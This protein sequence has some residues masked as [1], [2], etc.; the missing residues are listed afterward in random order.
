MGIVYEVEHVHTTE[1]LALKLGLA[2]D[3]DM[4]ERFRREARTWARLSHDHVVRIIDA[5][6]STTRNAPYLVMELLDGFNLEALVIHRGPIPPARVVDLLWQIARAVDQAHS[7]GIVHRDLKPENVFIHRVPDGRAMVK[8][9]DWGIAKNLDD[10]TTDIT[11]TGAILGTPLYMAP[12]QAVGKVDAIGRASDI[13]AVGLIA[14]YLLTGDDYWQADDTGVLLQRVGRGATSKP[15]LRWSWLP[16]G[17]DEWFAR[18]CMREP[19]KRWS[20]VGEQAEALREAFDLSRDTLPQALVAERLGAWLSGGAPR[21]QP[22]VGP[23]AKADREDAHRP[24]ST[25]RPARRFAPREP[26]LEP[27]PMARR[28]SLLAPG[29]IL[30]AAMFVVAIARLVPSR[31][32]PVALAKAPIPV[33]TVVTPATIAPAEAEPAASSAPA[34]DGPDAATAAPDGPDAHVTARPADGESAENMMRAAQTELDRGGRER[35]E[36]ARDLVERALELN[37]A[38]AEAWLT[39]GAAQDALGD[40]ASALTAYRS[41]VT[42]ARGARVRECRA[43]AR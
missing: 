32:P 12:E 5:D 2:A 34:P 7:V 25:T 13:W 37:P 26:P 3:G 21:E 29:V 19:S 41:C 40:H 30:V 24:G 20:S 23:P 9:L 4:L 6:T 18:S 38:S 43:L 33:V 17:F 15:S 11:K 39:L 42:S 16:R 31:P 22:G 8:I 27:V 28:W 1:R 35:F 10:E 14:T 36:K